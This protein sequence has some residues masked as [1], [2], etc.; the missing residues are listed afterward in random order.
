[1]DL[2][3]LQ[4]ASS[5]FG[6]AGS[7]GDEDRKII[8]GILKEAGF[9][10]DIYILSDAEIAFYSIFGEGDGVLI[11]AGTGTIGLGRRAGGEFYRAGGW[12]Y[13]LGDEGSGFFIGQRALNSALKSY[14]GQ[15]DKT[16]LEREISD[17][18]GIEKI[19]EIIGIVYKERE[20]V[21][22]IASI[23]PLVFKCAERGDDVS[24]EIID[25]AAE[26]IA[27]LA[28]AVVEGAGID[29]PIKLSITG[30]LVAGRK[31]FL[32][33]IEEK[34]KLRGIHFTFTPS[35]L[36]PVYGALLYG[37]KKAGIEFKPSIFT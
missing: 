21:K 20:K 7:W 29:L 37:M 15:A 28:R 9:S 26:S 2:S 4:I 18:L 13:L 23:A 12:G 30:G 16:I 19:E 31:N 24:G 1:M 25:E 22:L 6:L 14:D 5:T 32:H 10:E 11:I 35:S 3:S 8:K 36:P 34:I 27:N 33:L 17:F